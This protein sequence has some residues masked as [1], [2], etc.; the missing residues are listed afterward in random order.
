MYQ[1]LT[2]LVSVS[3]SAIVFMI[4]IYIWIPEAVF[5]SIYGSSS[6]IPLQG[7][8]VIEKN[9]DYSELAERPIFQ[10]SRRFK[11]LAD[12][13]ADSKK[14][15]IP[16][17]PQVKGVAIS[18]PGDKFAF[19]Q[20]SEDGVVY[21]LRVGQVMNEKWT[22][23]EINLIQVLLIDELGNEIALDTSF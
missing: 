11:A 7:S 3:F 15:L 6:D 2:K 17:S 21:Q 14:S 22:V 5:A 1:K 12:D 13:G 4:S 8:S 16:E 18:D 9:I 23:K 10:K 19:I 20:S